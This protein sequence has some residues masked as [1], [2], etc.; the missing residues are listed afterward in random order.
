MNEV[1]YHERTLLGAV[2]SYLKSLVHVRPHLVK[3]FEGLLEEMAERWLAGEQANLLDAV[4]GVWLHDHLRQ[5]NDRRL[6]A[7]VIGDFYRWARKTGLSQ[8]DPL[9]NPATTG[10]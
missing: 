6:A 3:R 2:D 4:D 9:G 10:D 7:Q 5:T 8:H 1:L